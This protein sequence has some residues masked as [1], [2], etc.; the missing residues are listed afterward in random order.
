LHDQ[1]DESA[2]SDRFTGGHVERA[3]LTE[4]DPNIEI[5][6]DV[7][8]FRLTLWQDGKE[9]KS[10]RIGVGQ[11]EYPIIIGVREASEIILNPPWIPPASD[12]VSGHKGVKPGEYIKA[13]DARN[14]LGKVKIPLGGGYLIHQAQGAGDLGHLVSHG[15]VRMMLADLYDL[16][17]KINAAYGYPLSA[18]QLALG[19]R[20][21][22]TITGTLPAPLQVDIN[23]DTLVVEG[24]TLHIYPDV[25]DRGTNTVARVRAELEASGADAAALDDDTIERMLARVKPHMEY[26]V[27]L[28]SISAGRAL[29]DGELRPIIGTAIK[30]RQRATMRHAARED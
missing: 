22:R 17:E 16:T 27:S 13:S 14:P 30:Q 8:A 1:Y 20:T 25:Y 19:K 2:W 10:Y 18:K 4:N 15:C 7:P 11:K 29:E 28:E 12:W 5:T 26:V 6:V 9:V 24:G 21:K 3:E 23:Y